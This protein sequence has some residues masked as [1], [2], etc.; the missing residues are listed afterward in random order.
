MSVLTPERTVSRSL[1]EGFLEEVPSE[2]GP[3]A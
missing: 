3:G 2:P 1:G